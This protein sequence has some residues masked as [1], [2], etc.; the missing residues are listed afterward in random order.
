MLIQSL[1]LRMCLKQPHVSSFLLE[2]SSSSL[3][4]PGTKQERR[5]VAKEVQT[6]YSIQSWYSKRGIDLAELESVPGFVA[7]FCTKNDCGVILSSTHCGAIVLSGCCI[8]KSSQEP[9]NM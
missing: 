2:S 5:S 7:S 4:Y 6:F 3:T 9:L 1:K 8:V